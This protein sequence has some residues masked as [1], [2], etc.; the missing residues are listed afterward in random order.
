METGG[1]DNLFHCVAFMPTVRIY[2]KSLCIQ[3]VS[4]MYANSVN[5]CSRPWSCFVQI[6]CPNKNFGNN[7]A[8][9]CWSLFFA[10][11][12]KFNF[13]QR[14]TCYER[15]RRIEMKIP[16]MRARR[17][18]MQTPPP[19]LTGGA[20]ETQLLWFI[21]FLPTSLR[22]AFSYLDLIT[23]FWESFSRRGAHTIERSPHGIIF[24]SRLLT[25][26]FNSCAF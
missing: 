6:W 19:G 2:I 14:S 25:S 16:Q 7:S 3:P 18:K 21:F 10:L 15:G 22:Q 26:I 13:S 1:P 4:K 20:R 9:F 23:T 11:R 12:K 24:S 17:G 8:N 5:F